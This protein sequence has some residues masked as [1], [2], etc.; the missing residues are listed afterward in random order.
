MNKFD[1]IAAILE[2]EY[3]IEIKPSQEGWGSG[4]DP[5]YVSIV[6]M[7]AKGE[8]EDIPILAKMP[9]G[10]VFHTLEFLK[11]SQEQI[12]S[13]IRHEIRYILS[14]NLFSFKNGQREVFRAGYDPTSFVCLY[15]IFENIR[16]DNEVNFDMFAKKRLDKKISIIKPRYPHHVY[17]INM[18]KSF[19][20][21]QLENISWLRKE[22]SDTKQYF[23]EALKDTKESYN[24]LMDSV[25]P[26]YRH[27]VEFA[28]DIRLTELILGELDKHSGRIITDIIGKLGE[29]DI[30]FF[31]SI[32]KTNIDSAITERVK[33]ILKHIPDWMVAY[34]KQIVRMEMIEQDTLFLSFVIKPWQEST[35]GDSLKGTL[36]NSSQSP[37][38]QSLTKDQAKTYRELRNS[39]V[40]VSQILKRNISNIFPTEDSVFEGKYFTGKHLNTLAL[41]TEIQTNS[42]RIY[43]RKASGKDIPVFFSFL[44]DISSSMR[45]ED[46]LVNAI[47]GLILISEVLSDLKLPF[48]IGLFNEEYFL[49][50]DF[51]VPYENVIP[52]I[53]NIAPQKGTNLGLALEKEKKHI[54]LFQK[55]SHK[56]GILVLFSDGEPTKGMKK[57]EL[58]VYANMLKLEVPFAVVG[59]GNNATSIKSIFGSNT[60]IL[61][62]I[63]NLPIAF[64]RIVEHQ[65]R[66]FL[67]R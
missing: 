64:A 53:L 19:Y 34:A 5:K 45:K 11:A 44:L 10:I 35:S 23:E 21:E 7:W 36:S 2:R 51:G 27:L 62:S 3:D 17:L 40:A 25:W 52:S 1:Q 32:K 65:L 54:E 29:Q 18:C 39:V 60:I 66:K 28:H 42:G 46:K 15:S 14:T 6:D 20:K 59:V 31:E 61:K 22:I 26:R 9:A 37:N 67:K 55:Q 58:T 56:K 12:L 50:K 8:V 63:N 38:N 4:Y 47:K 49:L 16:L 41:A 57:E 30:R 43:N 13:D 33:H 48:S 24:I